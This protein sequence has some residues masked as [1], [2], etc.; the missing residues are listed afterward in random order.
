MIIKVPNGFVTM[1]DVIDAVCPSCGYETPYE[2][3]DK[4]LHD[5]RFD[6]ACI[7][8]ICKG[9]RQKLGVSSDYKGNTVCWLKKTE[10]P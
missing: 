4:R 7:Y 10:T 1:P 6:D 3:F 5:D 8:I 9:C 2:K